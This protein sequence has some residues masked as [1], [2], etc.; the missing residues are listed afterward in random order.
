MGAGPMQVVAWYVPMAVGGCIL[1]G[2]GALVLHRIPG[3][4]LAI[5]TCVAIIIDSLLFTIAPD[6]ANYWA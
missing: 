1:A 5:I 6:G 4:I 2:I 3:K